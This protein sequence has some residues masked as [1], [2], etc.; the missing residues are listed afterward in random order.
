MDELKKAG[1]AMATTKENTVVAN[2]G[3]TGTELAERPR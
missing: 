1:L 2:T 3:V